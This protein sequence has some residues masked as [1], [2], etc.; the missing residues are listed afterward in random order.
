MKDK[1]ISSM[2]RRCWLNTKESMIEGTDNCRRLGSQDCTTQRLCHRN[3]NC[4][5]WT[6]SNGSRSERCLFNDLDRDGRAE[7]TPLL[8]SCPFQ[9]EIGR[10]FP[11]FLLCAR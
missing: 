3:W 9:L 7:R 4:G 11:T 5:N 2:R 10:D 1:S 8:I 6:K